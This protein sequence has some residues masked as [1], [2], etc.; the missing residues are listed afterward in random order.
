MVVS[1]QQLTKYSST[2]YNASPTLLP[3]NIASLITAIALAARLSLRC[4]SLFIEALLESAKYSTSLS[5]GL[6]R[7]ALI[8][9]LSTAKKLHE[10]TASAA[11]T[12]TTTDG[13][14]STT[15][16]VTGIDNDDEK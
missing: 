13:T 7:Q 2:I 9:A 11:M 16:A 15:A 1:T 8:N 5:F 3:E 6:S 14:A 4:S 10:L 12:T